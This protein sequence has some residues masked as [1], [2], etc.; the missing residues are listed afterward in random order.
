[1]NPSVMTQYY[2][3]GD[4]LFFD[5]APV[6]YN[7]WT[8]YQSGTT[9]LLKN[10]KSFKL[11]LTDDVQIHHEGDMAWSAAVLKEEATT[12]TGKQEMATMRWTVI[13]Q[14]MDGKWLIVHEHTSEA[15]Q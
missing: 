8:E 11:S 9:E 12:S 4:R 14:K 15:L 2:A 6:K 3:Q 10:Y 13:F 1:M 7:N 5:I